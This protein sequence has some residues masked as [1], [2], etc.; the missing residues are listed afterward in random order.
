MLG[1]ASLSPPQASAQLSPVPGGVLVD[2]TSPSSGVRVRGAVTVSASVSSTR[3]GSVTAVQ[4][5]VNGG[6]LGAAVTTAPYSVT[7]NASA[8]TDGWHTLTAVARD[9][10][11]LE[12]SSDPVTVRVSNTAPPP[13]A[14][15][16]YEETDPS[17]TYGVG[18]IQR[19]PYDWHAWSG[20]GAVQ[21]MTPGATVTFSFIGTSVTWIGYR[22]LDSG[23]ARVLVDGV[24]LSDVDLFARREESSSR[25]YTVTGLTDSSHELT[26]EVTG[27]K[28]AESSLSNIV[29]DAFDVPAPLVSHLQETDPF[30]SY[31][32]GW[33]AGDVSMPWSGGTATV[34]TD[35]GAQATLIFEG[36][37]ISWIGYRGPDTGIAFAFLDGSF[38]GEIDT[39]SPSARIQDTLFTATDLA[40]GVGHTLTIE[41]SG[42]RNA[43]STGTRILVDAF[44]V[45]TLGTRFQETDW[46]VT[47]T[48][49]WVHGNLNRPWSEGTVA[50]SNADGAQATFSF[51]GTSVSWIGFH[52]E[53]TGIARVYL[54]GVFVTLVD[55]YTPTEGFQNTLFSATGLDGASH[56]LTIEATG[57]KNAASTNNYVI[58]DA[59]DVRP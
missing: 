7:W 37:A 24:F 43:D 11:G 27:R 59:F 9:A 38:A 20:G 23:I 16:R 47:Y 18:W 45:T 46:S 31:T 39:Y 51:S 54:D 55:T 52:S 25:V 3:S 48:G 44:D 2:I 26:I 36:T 8:A 34:S 22:G 40:D 13:M 56:T 49:D 12:F 53:R 14:V 35:P 50:G 4:F 33:S 10:S 28:N 30:V 41:A 29:V 21:A 58:V 42:F 6:D 5:K 32:A 1:A 17:V 57:W 15:E 19:N